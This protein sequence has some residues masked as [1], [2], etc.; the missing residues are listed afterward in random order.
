MSVPAA[1]QDEIMKALM[2]DKALLKSS[3]ISPPAPIT[4][5]DIVADMQAIANPGQGSQS[6]AAN[7]NMG[8]PTAKGT[9]VEHIDLENFFNVPGLQKMLKNDK[10]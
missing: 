4:A 9:G 7:R 5:E 3:T 10:R 6:I 8:R 1:S 2:R